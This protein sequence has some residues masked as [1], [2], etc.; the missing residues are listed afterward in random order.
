MPIL[1]V[2]NNHYDTYF[3][4]KLHQMSGSTLMAA[5]AR[6]DSMNKETGLT[7]CYCQSYNSS[8]DYIG[9]R[10]IRF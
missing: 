9:T 5:G 1:S 2:S 8:S 6:Y 4:D 3:C 7:C 10:L